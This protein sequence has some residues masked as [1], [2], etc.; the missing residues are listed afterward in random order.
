MDA[1]IAYLMGH[2]ASYVIVAVCAGNATAVILG[3][4]NIQKSFEKHE[5]DDERR[6]K[7]NIER[8]NIIEARL[9]EIASNGRRS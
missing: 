6:H 9:Y 8:F 7:E 2:Y 3:L 1:V 5:E 4:K